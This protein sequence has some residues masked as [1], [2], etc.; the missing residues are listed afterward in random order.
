M[1]KAAGGDRD[2]SE[3]ERVWQE[4][5]PSWADRFT[6]WVD[7]LPGPNWPYYSAMGLLVFSLQ[8]AVVWAVG[9]YPVGTLLPPH[10]FIAGIWPFFLALMRY[11]DDRASG[12]LTRPCGL[13]SRWAMGTRDAWSTN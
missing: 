5:A 8:T 13:L 7:R 2:H 12:A 3:G 11:L 4:Y 1:A 9:A 10:A 6:A